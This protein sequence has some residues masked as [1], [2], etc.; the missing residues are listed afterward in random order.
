VVRIPADLDPAETAPLLCAGTAVFNG[1][2]K[3]HVD[4]GSLVAVQGLGG[5]GHLAVQYVRAMGSRGE[6]KREFALKLGAHEYIDSSQ[7]DVAAQLT[8]MGG[9]ALI[10]STAPNGKAMSELLDGLENAGKLL[11]LAPVGPVEFNTGPLVFRAL[12]IH[13][14]PTGHAID[15]E[16]AVEFARRNGVKCMIERF[17]LADASKALDSV[18]E[19]KPRFRNVL[20]M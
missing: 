6:D 13:G 20:V 15:T 9:A 16:D 2:R 3:L 8:K 18:R 10:V 19:G 12:S 17:P 11:L 7:G 4:Q 14:W 5:L 1:I